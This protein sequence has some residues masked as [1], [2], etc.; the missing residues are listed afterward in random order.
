LKFVKEEMLKPLL[1]AAGEV[2]RMLNGLIASIEAWRKVNPA[3]NWKLET[4]N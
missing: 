4:G 1:E 2:S 3:G